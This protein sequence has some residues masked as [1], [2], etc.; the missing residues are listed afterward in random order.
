MSRFKLIGVVAGA[1]S[2]VADAIN[3]HLA[4]KLSGGA[5]VLL[6][7]FRTE[8]LI[9][10]EF[11]HQLLASDVT[12]ADLVQLSS[13]QRPNSSLWTDKALHISLERRLG[14]ATSK[15]V[16]DTLEDMNSVLTTLKE[17]LK[18]EN[19]ALT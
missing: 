13:R 5:S 15:L 19:P 18:V 17:K 14:S 8:E 2:L 3:L 4:T 11:V 6:R 7:Q 1:W 9:F 16:L 12:E 10:R